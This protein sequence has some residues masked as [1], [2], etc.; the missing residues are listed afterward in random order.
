MEF[1]PPWLHHKFGKKKKKKK[2]SPII[3]FDS[4]DGCLKRII[5]DETLAKLH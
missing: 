3:W 1:L 5:D 2:I 4:S